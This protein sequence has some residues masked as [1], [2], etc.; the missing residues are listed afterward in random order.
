MKCFCQLSLASYNVFR[1]IPLSLTK[2]RGEAGS[3]PVLRV[4]REQVLELMRSKPSDERSLADV[5]QFPYSLA[6]TS[7]T[8]ASQTADVNVQSCFRTSKGL[9]AGDRTPFK[10]GGLC[11]GQVRKLESN[12]KSDYFRSQ[13][14]IRLQS[15]FVD[16]PCG[17]VLHGYAWN[18]TWCFNFIFDIL[19][20]RLC[21]N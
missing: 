17:F 1:L 14:Y 4:A 20:C 16:L 5:S 10:G 3:G 12:T 15:T 21:K 6:S 8:T 7:H 13:I 11:H 2:P 18:M 9:F 19:F